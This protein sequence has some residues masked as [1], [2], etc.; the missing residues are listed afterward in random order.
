MSKSLYGIV[1]LHVINSDG[2][3]VLTAFIE[4]MDLTLD[5]NPDL[6][7]TVDGIQM[8]EIQFRGGE[9]GL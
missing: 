9:R 3:E 8:K 2:E 6:N 7:L 5:P 1:E 4:D